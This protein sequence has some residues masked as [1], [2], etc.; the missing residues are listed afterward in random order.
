VVIHRPRPRLPHCNA[1]HRGQHAASVSVLLA[2]L[3]RSLPGRASR[4]KLVGH[5]AHRARVE[6]HRVRLR[7]GRRPHGPGRA[8]GR[9]WPGHRRGPEPGRRGARPVTGATLGLG[10]VHALVD[11]ADN[12]DAAALGEPFDLAHT[13]PKWSAEQA[14][15]VLI[16]PR[17][18]GTAGLDP[19]RWTW[20]VRLACLPDIPGHDHAVLHGVGALVGAR[21]PVRVGS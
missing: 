5:L 14:L 17:P 11:D 9:V 6:R 3:A 13:R 10:N 21:S 12:L 16:T 8:G 2:S 4:L 7:P 20:P 1:D 18:A 19:S 15:E